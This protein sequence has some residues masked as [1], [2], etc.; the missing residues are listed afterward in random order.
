MSKAT[1]KLSPKRNRG[2]DQELVKVVR[3][4]VE[5]TLWG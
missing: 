1:A 2:D 3:S 4:P 5:L